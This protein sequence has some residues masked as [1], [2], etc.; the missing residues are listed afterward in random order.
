MERKDDVQLIHRILSGDDEAFNILVRKHQKSVHALVWQKIGD[1]HHAEEVTQDIFLQA[2]KKLSTLKDPNQ[3]AGWLYAVANRLCIDWMRKQKPATQPLDDA[4][5]K[6]IDNLTYE[7]YVSEQ[8]ESEATECRYETVEKLLAKL[9]ESERTVM[10][11]YYLSEMRAKE[12]GKSLDVSVNTVRSR[13]HRARK[14]LQ[15]DQE[16]LIQEFLGSVQITDLEVCDSRWR[17]IAKMFSEADA[18]KR[19]HSEIESLLRIHPETPELL[20]TAYWGYMN[21]P[22][23]IKNVPNSLFDKMLQYSKTE[24]YL[25]ALLGLAERSADV[26]QEWHY[27]QRVIDECTISDGPSSWYW[28]A[29]EKMLRL[30]EED[31][32]LTSDDY[33]D[34]LIDR[35]LQVHLAYCKETQQW[36]GGAYTEAVKYRLKFNIRL[37]KALET[38]EH[39][40]IRLGEEEEQRW[41]VEWEQKWL[42]EPNKGYVEKAY[43][44]ISRLRAEIYFQQERW[45]EAYDGLLTNAPDFLE[46]LSERF[47]EDI[48]NYFYM[49]G[50]SAEG[51]GDW[52]TARRYY[53]DAHFAPTPHAKA[54]TGLKRIYNQT[55]RRPTDTFEAFLKDTE[56]EYRIREDTDREKIRQRLIA[57]RL[58]K[59][60]TDFRLQTLQGETYTLSAMSGKIVLLEIGNSRTREHNRKIPEVKLVYKHFSKNDDVVVWGINDGITTHQ[61][62]KFIDGHQVPWPILLDP[63]GEVRKAYQIMGIPCFILIDR[64]GNWQYIC[65]ALDPTSG[66]PL[67]WMIE[68]LL[69]H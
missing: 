58:N 68:A 47:N 13:L 28:G 36:F 30:A 1:F 34:E 19:I 26:H 31:R 50:R 45:R 57:N 2:Y 12:I 54:R 69:S 64:E 18:Q 48:T 33:L 21:L 52:E 4:S 42:V 66:Q 29:Y 6:I 25:T 51:I 56:T 24:A 49:L 35:C 15:A 39:A 37:D 8:R 65:R 16:L 20:N 46:S 61:V 32:S 38:L 14:R 3:F 22:D 9:P 55:E 41:L 63:H 27:Y 17:L 40:E 5:V 7:R 53:A 23:G 10:M 44:E 60:A 11:L 67:I 43:K 62:R 59:K